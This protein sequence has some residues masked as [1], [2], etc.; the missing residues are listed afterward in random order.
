MKQKEVAEVV[1][2]SLRKIQELESVRDQ[3]KDFDRRKRSIEMH[4]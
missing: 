2:N 4:K 3:I 1:N